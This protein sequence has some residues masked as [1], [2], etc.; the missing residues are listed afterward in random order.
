[1]QIPKYVIYIKKN[2]GNQDNSLRRIAKKLK[3]T[4]IENRTPI[5]FFPYENITVIQKML[6]FICNNYMYKNKQNLYIEI[7][8][9]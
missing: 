6:I 8:I 2:I 5:H 3:Y 4:D 1:M 9:S 7:K